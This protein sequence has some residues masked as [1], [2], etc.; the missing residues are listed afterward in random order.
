MTRSFDSQRTPLTMLY[1]IMLPLL[2]FSYWP[3]LQLGTRYGMHLDISLLYIACLVFVVARLAIAIKQRELAHI[4]AF[5]RTSRPLLALTG[6]LVIAAASIAW[7]DNPFRAVTTVVFSAAMLANMLF[8]AYDYKVLHRHA[9]LYVKL[10]SVATIGLAAFALWQLFFDAIGWHGVTLLPATYSSTVFG[11]ARPIGFCLEPQFLGNLMLIPALFASWTILSQR[12][13][14]QG[15]TIYAVA[16]FACLTILLTLSRGAIYALAAG[17]AIQLV[18]AAVRQPRTRERVIRVIS[19]TLASVVVALGAVYSAATI[20]T[21]DNIDGYEAVS[22]YADQLTLGAISLPAPARSDESSRA[23]AS[24]ATRPSTEPT[25]D[26]AGYVRESTDSRLAM[27]SLALKLWNERAA[28]RLFGI[29]IGSFG[30][31][32][33]AYD[34]RY[35]TS[36]IVNNHYLEMLVETGIVGAGCFVAGLGMLVYGAMRRAAYGAATILL[37][38]LLQWSFFSGS[39][40]VIHV[41][42]AAGVVAG[43]LVHTKTPRRT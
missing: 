10:L 20:N 1:R 15:N 17:L 14:I 6:W 38:L 32:A 13:T 33:H 43:L 41:W 29:G 42:V 35:S 7:S 25:D 39:A 16:F 5:A 28:T 22:K 40:N 12:T 24:A 9:V 27:S 3:L 8:I 26:T 21:R 37:A 30:L 23:A 4:A 11:F 31:S 2:I 18:L 34:P 19:I 36:S